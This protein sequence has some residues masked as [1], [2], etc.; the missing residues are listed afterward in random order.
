MNWGF[1]MDEK[2]TNSHQ[3]DDAM[4]QGFFDAARTPAQDAAPT[5]DFMARMLNDAFDVQDAMAPVAQPAPR[6]PWYVALMEAI[7]GWPSLA[8]MAVA[9]VAGVWIG[10]TGPSALADFAVTGGGEYASAALASDYGLTSGFETL[11]GG[12]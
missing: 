5:D 1:R 11:L 8:G 6:R 7:G 12:S 2:M 4:L 3:S 10:V 9:T